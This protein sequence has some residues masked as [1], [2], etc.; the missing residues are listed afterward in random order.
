MEQSVVTC[1]LDSTALS[2]KVKGDAYLVRCADFIKLA[3]CCICSHSIHRIM[4]QILAVI[5]DSSES[6]KLD[7]MANRLRKHKTKSVYVTY[8]MSVCI[9][10][11][12]YSIHYYSNKYIWQLVMQ[13]GL[14][15]D[16]I[17]YEKL[18]SKSG[19]QLWK[20]GLTCG[21]P[22]SFLFT[23]VKKQNRLFWSYS[24]SAIIRYCLIGR[25]VSCPIR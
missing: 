5:L 20:T 15:W 17:P 3:D 24:A 16:C 12:L 9:H 1:W 22:W 10:R 11:T 4:T 25:A 8:N 7:N 18:N 6:Q 19:P 23:S 21:Q 13:T 2:V 14:K